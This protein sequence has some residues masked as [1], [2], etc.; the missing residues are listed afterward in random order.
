M[1]HELV[2]V[3]QK[4]W[5]DLLL[6]EVLRLMQW[7]NPFMWIYAGFIR[8]NHE[9][10]ADE[11]ALQLTSHPAVYRAALLN[12]IVGTPVVNLANTFNYSLNKKRFNMMKN[13]ITS[14]WRKMKIFLILPVF[15]I[16]LYAFAKPEYRYNTSGLKTGN[17]DNSPI[18]QVKELKGT[19]MQQDGKPLPGA[20]IVI[21]GTTV[22]TISDA[23][24]LFKLINVPDEG[25][26][27][28]SFVGYKTKV[29][30]AVFNTDMII[31]MVRDTVKLGSIRTNVPPPPPPPGD[32]V[33]QDKTPIADV[34]PPPPPPPPVDMI[35]GGPAPLVVLDGKIT[36]INPG[37][38]D[39]STIES[40]TVLKAEEATK[41]YG[42]KG[43]N[44]V[45]EVTSKKKDVYVMV[46][47][48][49]QFPG[50]EPAM[51]S[52]ISS[53]IKYPVDA[54]KKNITGEVL[55]NFV[56]S[57]NGK[58]KN[59]KVEKSVNPLLDAEAIRVISSM[60]DWKPGTQGGKSV[61]V[62]MMVPISF[63]LDKVSR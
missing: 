62:N 28:I 41:K 35:G 34:P 39:P 26:L 58:I 4:H 54:A 6:I 36:D 51:M 60:P 27:V 12:Q 43:K 29:I 31:K 23:K 49:P 24:G 20:I 56:V 37:K 61:E 44:G 10:L 2:H 46:E 1:N 47:E 13:I 19:V 8:L 14:P 63:A 16:V 3:R 30:K 15:A 38:M 33:S 48:M 7:A 45:I 55:V 40:M 18:T 25:S 5:F 22:G 53:N 32:K 50:G 42:E 57:N 21:Q 59:V 9:Y 52:W 11:M 17:Q